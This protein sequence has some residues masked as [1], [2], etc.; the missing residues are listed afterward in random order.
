VNAR[1]PALRR[2]LSF[3]L[4]AILL[5]PA[6]GCKGHFKSF[7]ARFHHRKARSKPNTTDYADN[8]QQA[9]SS[10]QLAIMK[11][12][13]FS[14][15]QPQVQ[16]FYD[17]RNF[18]LAWIRD[19]KPTPEATALIDLF[20]N[21][22]KKGLKP[23]DYDASRWAQRVQRLAA[24]HS[25]NDTSDSAQDE[26]AQFDA[27]MTIAA[28]RFVS[29]LHL[30]RINPQSLN[31]DIDVPARRAA[32]DLPGFLDDTLV[33]AGDV[34]SAI[35]GI[36]PQ[37]AI[38]AATEKALPQ[39]LQLAQQQ[40]AAQALPPAA[41]PIA[42]G[43]GYPAMHPLMLRLQL[44]GD[45]PGYEPPAPPASTQAPG[46]STPA[47]PPAARSWAHPLARLKARSAA[48]SA[49]R[50][51]AQSAAV[52]AAQPPV[53]EPVHYSSTFDSAASDAVKHYQLR[54]GI[55]PDGK[56]T[57]ATIDSLNVPMSV[58][59]QQLDDA[60]ER[61]RWMP[62]N[63]VNPRLFANL[64]EFYV[65]AY[66]PDHSLAFKM[67]VVDGE[68]NGHDTPMFVRT[69]RFLIFR[70]YW[71]LPTS[72]V[73]KELMKHLT[74]GGRGYLESH[75]YE[76]VTNAGDPVSDFTVDDLEHSRYLVR[77]KP[78][79]KN[80]LGLV[81][82]MFPNEYDIYMHST[83]EMNLFNLT[84]RDRSHG[85]VRLNDAEKMANWVLTGQSEWD[86]GKIH[87]A[88][89][90]GDE[91]NNKQVN[92]KTPLPVVIGYFTAMADEDGSIHFYDDLYG[93]D[94]ELEAALNKGIPYEQSPVKI[95]PKL[96]PGETE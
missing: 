38:Y 48:R 35:S 57:Q 55:T 89:F 43:G 24:I 94:K 5:L 17:D 59:V 69:M 83:P 62:D 11:W 79:P 75:D 40:Q 67:K 15:Y 78:G 37:N 86:A 10:P 28:M 39:Y 56:L 74:S 22:D 6:G 33:D 34:P 9:V 88:M 53:P 51:Q 72:I 80:S 4:L 76:V 65:R 31:F 61:W 82:F 13:N 81:K 50:A 87:D 2:S 90:G 42:P 96:I 49:A 85:C 19:G 84:R 27:A 64:P 63:F 1:T 25:A 70:P 58:R 36:E 66:E 23:E 44:E 77:Q 91:N 60:L 18:E 32:F 16:T 52:T 71:N 93:Y 92:L 3:C 95:N 12:S 73:K 8:V 29:D 47:A 68:A 41:K 20:N 30:G 21:A 45:A 14:D 54:H 26:V 46:E 7:F